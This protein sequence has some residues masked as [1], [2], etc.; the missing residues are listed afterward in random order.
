MDADKKIL[1]KEG[2]RWLRV[3]TLTLTLI[4]PIINALNARLKMQ[5]AQQEAALKARSNTTMDDTRA[6]LIAVGSRL[7]E[8]LA[9]LKNN[10]YGQDLLKRGEEVAGELVERGSHLSQFLS[11]R[12]SQW[13]RDV[14]K[15]SSDFTQDWAERGEEMSRELRRRGRQAAERS[16]PA[17]LWAGFGVGLL[18]TAAAVY[19]ILRKRM[20]QQQFAEEPHIELPVHESTNNVIEGNF[21]RSSS[22]QTET[23]QAPTHTPTPVEVKT[24]QH[25]HKAASAAPGDAVLVGVV[26]TRRYYPIET[27]LEQLG[28]V[29]KE[30]L[31][32]VYF[33]S[34]DEARAQGFS[35][36]E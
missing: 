17:L 26:N 13:T 29:E 9:E 27:P 10:P 7:N 18:T 14:A 15:R 2:A 3:G 24:D 1:L 32:V 33:A 22:L 36:V 21:M 8:T 34:E 11:E 4:G 23:P 20:E 19:M 25:E 5:E 12:G 35:S 6:R 30:P 16:N 28:P 31:D